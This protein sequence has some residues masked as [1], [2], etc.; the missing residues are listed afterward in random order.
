[1]ASLTISHLSKSFG[2]FE[3]LSDVTLDVEKG[4]FICLLGG[5]GCGK[6]TLLRMIA[7]LESH[8]RGEMLL[9]GKD[10]TTVSCHE[11][12][13]GMVFQSLALFPHLDVLD[14][15]AFNSSSVPPNWTMF[16]PLPVM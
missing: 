10:V 12:G 5:S 7:G 9:G 6:T 1:M 4:E 2:S 13:I 11:R 8:D 16:P 15:V 3:A 14:N